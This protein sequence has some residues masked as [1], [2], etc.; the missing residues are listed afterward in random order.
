MSAT[1]IFVDKLDDISDVL[2]ASIA[3]QHNLSD[4]YNGKLS[5]ARLKL[6]QN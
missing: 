2:S 6:P 1:F 3:K 4:V 5:D